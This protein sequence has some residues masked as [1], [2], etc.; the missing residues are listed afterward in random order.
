[1]MRSWKDWSGNDRKKDL[2]LRSIGCV[3]W[4]NFKFRICKP[5]ICIR[6]MWLLW[7]I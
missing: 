6:I 2:C 1:L 4:R 7:F 3:R 5:Q